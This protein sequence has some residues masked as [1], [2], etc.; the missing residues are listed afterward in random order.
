MYTMARVTGILHV[1]VH[2]ESRARSPASIRSMWN[3]TQKM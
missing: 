2:R 3:L 1:N